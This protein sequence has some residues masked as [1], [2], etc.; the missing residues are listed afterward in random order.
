MLLFALKFK[1]SSQ[2]WAM[3]VN[4]LMLSM[5][6]F[7]DCIIITPSSAK[8]NATILHIHVLVF[9]PSRFSYS[10]SII[11]YVM[12]RNKLLDPV[13]PC[14][15]PLVTSIYVTLKHVVEVRVYAQFV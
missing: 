2:S 14:L 7:K 13:H 1:L 3:S 10:F 9:N 8:N 15:I 12:S 11:M 6:S 5:V 4:I